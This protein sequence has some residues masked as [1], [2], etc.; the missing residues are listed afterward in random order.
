MV[1]VLSSD[2]LN[3]H[4]I[5]GVSGHVIFT[6]HHRQCSGPVHVTHSENWIIVSL[7]PLQCSKHY[8]TDVVTIVS[9]PECKVK[10]T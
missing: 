10:T 1:A 6:A 8:I 4:L 2:L 3:V 5:D 7:T 9:L